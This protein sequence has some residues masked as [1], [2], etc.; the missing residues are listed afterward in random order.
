LAGGSAIWLDRARRHEALLR[1]PSIPTQTLKISRERLAEALSVIRSTNADASPRA[2]RQILLAVQ[3]AKRVA[4]S[5]L[6][7][8]REASQLRKQ[9]GK[10]AALVDHYYA[11]YRDIQSLLARRDRELAETAL[12]ALRR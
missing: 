12:V 3:R 2:K 6:R 8:C 11:A 7:L 10:L 4:A 1:D 9:L 5:T